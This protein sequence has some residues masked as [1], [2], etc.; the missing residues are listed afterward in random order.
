[1]RLHRLLLCLAVLFFLTAQV[2]AQS[3]VS[4][5]SSTYSDPAT[6]E[7]KQF[8]EGPQSSDLNQR[9]K[10]PAGSSLAKMEIGQSQAT[11]PQ[12]YL[13]KA[14]LFLDAIS[15]N[16]NYSITVLEFLEIQKTDTDWIIVDIRPADRYAAG[17][18][19][20]S[21]NIPYSDLVLMMD[22][23]PA[24]KKVAVYSDYDTDAAFG[25]MTLRVFGD[26]DAWVLEGGVPVWQSTGMTVV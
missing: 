8:L 6:N 25:V 19:E 23:I 20:N 18:I 10:P 16:S 14:D 4:P 2:C 21:M 12:N 5:A 9:G 13:A 22:M 15:A 1:M 17:H 3:D 24:S 7:I 26:R 11:R